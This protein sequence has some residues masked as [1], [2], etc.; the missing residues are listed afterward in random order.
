MRLRDTV[1]VV[2]KQLKVEVLVHTVQVRT[3]FSEAA[4]LQLDLES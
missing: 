4:G 2:A 3:F 1:L